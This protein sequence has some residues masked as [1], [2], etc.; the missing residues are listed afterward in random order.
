MAENAFSI[1]PF[2][3]KRVRVESTRSF[4][5]ALLNLQQVVEKTTIPQGRPKAQGSVPTREQFEQA[6]QQAA[7]Q[8]P[9][10]GKG[11]SRSTVGGCL[12]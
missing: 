2:E 12:P 6:T 7:A 5:E 9:L 8:T 1:Q 4:D 3:A 11:V 10:S